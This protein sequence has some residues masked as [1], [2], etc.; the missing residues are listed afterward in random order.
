M[1]KICFILSLLATLLAV[2]F[3]NVWA[4]VLAVLWAG[5]ILYAIEAELKREQA[6]RALKEAREWHDERVELLEDDIRDLAAAIHHSERQLASA[7]RAAQAAYKR[8][9]RGM[10]IHKSKQARKRAGRPQ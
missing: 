9:M 8:G 7:R 3:G 5:A 10:A 6:E 2:V 1:S 4:F